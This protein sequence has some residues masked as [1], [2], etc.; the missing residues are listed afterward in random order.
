[1]FIESPGVRGY[2]EFDGNCI[3][4]AVGQRGYSDGARCYRVIP[5][6][7]ITLP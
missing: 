2:I 3:V 1:M 6:V 7:S 5:N 4:G